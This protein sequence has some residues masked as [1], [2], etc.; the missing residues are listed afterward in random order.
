MKVLQCFR[1]LFR[2]MASARRIDVALRRSLA[3]CGLLVLLQPNVTLAAANPY[4]VFDSIGVSLEGGAGAT[5]GGSFSDSGYVMA[6][7]QFIPTANGLLTGIELNLFASGYYRPAKIDVS[8]RLNGPGGVPSGDIL[9]FGSITVTNDSLN[10]RLTT[11]VPSGQVSLS[12]N[13]PYWLVLASQDS[14]TSAA[15]VFSHEVSGYTAHSLVPD[16]LPANWTS[17]YRVGL[18]ATFGLPEFRVSAI[19]EPS[20][21]SLSLVALASGAIVRSLSRQKRP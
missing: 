9:A 20:S 4:V 11:F 12:A 2:P 19:P 5:I 10:K 14:H 13:T 3:I 18:P 8:L 17:T 15:W 6:A 16:P 1:S 7:T 21:L